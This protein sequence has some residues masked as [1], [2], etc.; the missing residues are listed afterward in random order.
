MKNTPTKEELEHMVYWESHTYSLINHTFF[1]NEL[2]GK[3]KNV[4]I[5][6]TKGELQKIIQFAIGQERIRRSK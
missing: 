1:N 2:K 3:D 5:K 4:S 6:I